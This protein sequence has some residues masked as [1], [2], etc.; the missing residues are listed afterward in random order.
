M[1]TNG[2][3]DKKTNGYDIKTSYRVDAALTLCLDN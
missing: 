3:N 1:K 2:I